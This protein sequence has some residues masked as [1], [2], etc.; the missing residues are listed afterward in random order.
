M[1]ACNRLRQ[2]GEGGISE[3]QQAAQAL[4]QAVAGSVACARSLAEARDGKKRS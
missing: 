1:G 3:M 4:R 2:E